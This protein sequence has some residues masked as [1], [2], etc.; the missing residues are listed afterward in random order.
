MSPGPA[1]F[2]GP[3][4]PA[5]L[6]DLGV[7]VAD[8]PA[9]TTLWRVYSAGGPHPGSWSTLRAFGPTGARFDHQDPPPHL[10]AV[11]MVAY[12]GEVAPLAVAERFASSRRVDR[13]AG[14]PHLTGFALAAPIV[15]ADLRGL[16]PTRA[17]AS[18]AVASGP[19]ERSR[20]WARAIWEATTGDLDGI[21]YRSSMYGGLT[22]VALWER[23]AAALP[24]TPIL[25]IPLDD[26]ALLLPLARAAASVGYTLQ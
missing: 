2:P 25:D 7:E 22:A 3:P 24:A 9:G 4:A 20:R 21:T 16:W 5:V 23:S 1:K 11:R 15:V 19:R 13:F 8:L 12:A 10:D 14:A 17:G 6:A 18:Q 26:P